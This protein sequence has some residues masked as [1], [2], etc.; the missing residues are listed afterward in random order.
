M[1]WICRLDGFT[2]FNCDCSAVTVRSKKNK[3]IGQG[4]LEVV[5]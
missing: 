5:V 4:T 1:A 2:A 3:I